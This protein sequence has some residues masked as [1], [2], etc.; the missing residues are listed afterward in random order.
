MFVRREQTNEDVGETNPCR[1]ACA[2]GAWKDEKTL[3]VRWFLLGGIQKGEFDIA[4]S[5]P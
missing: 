2:A 4:V 5:S 1:R 3:R